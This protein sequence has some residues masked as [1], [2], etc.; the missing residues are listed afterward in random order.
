M[1]TEHLTIEYSKGVEDMQNMLG[2]SIEESDA[3]FELF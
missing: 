1:T 3:V 2:V